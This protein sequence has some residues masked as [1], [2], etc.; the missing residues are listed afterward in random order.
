MTIKEQDK[1]QR[2]IQILKDKEEN[3][4]KEYEL[5][6]SNNQATVVFKKRMAYYEAM[7]EYNGALMAL[8][9]LDEAESEE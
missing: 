8:Q 5:F 2:L 7:A 9:C 3:Y 6:Q 4:K 1:I